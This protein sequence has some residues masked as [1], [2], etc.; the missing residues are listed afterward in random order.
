MTSFKE[1]IYDE[2]P[3]DDWVYINVDID[4]SEYDVSGGY[5]IIKLSDAI[6][7][8]SDIIKCSKCDKNAA[9]LDGQYPYDYQYNA[10]QEH[11]LKG[12]E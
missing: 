5:K 2:I 12:V 1:K 10:C 6:V 4:D 3:D 11:R 9:V 7:N 8:N